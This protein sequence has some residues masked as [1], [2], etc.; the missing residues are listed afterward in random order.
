MNEPDR[1]IE[2][3]FRRDV[4][5]VMSNHSEVVGIRLD[6]TEKTVARAAD[7]IEAQTANIDRLT[8]AILA[9]KE[10]IDRLERAVITMVSENAAQR[11][12][13]NNL[14]RLCTALVE[15]RAS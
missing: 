11:E 1:S 6:A 10:S 15:Q 3:K 2:A 5:N 12:T 13:A 9:Q 4:L 8:S 14:I 7:A